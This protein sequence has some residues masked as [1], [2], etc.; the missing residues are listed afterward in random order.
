MNRIHLLL[1]L[2]LA[3]VAVPFAAADTLQLVNNNLGIST[4]IGNVVL[5]QQGSNV[6]VTISANSG[7][8]LK[9]NGGSVYFNTNSILTAGSIGPVTIVAGGNTYTG[10]FGQFK[11]SQNVSSLG[12]FSYQYSNLQGA[13]AGI[14]SA[15]QISFVLSG[16]TVQQLELANSQGNMWG[17]H[18]CTA[19]GTSCSATT[20]FA[21][22][23]PGAE[24]PEP[25]TL[26]LL[27]TGLVGLAGLARKRLIKA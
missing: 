14:V 4:S 17:I 16:V 19:S 27:G 18:F 5:T 24:V 15:S 25:G 21:G 22:G 9:L 13:P 10:S 7:F 8:S 6:L 26:S 1:L 20:G 12:I 2:L 3:V 23:H 11:T